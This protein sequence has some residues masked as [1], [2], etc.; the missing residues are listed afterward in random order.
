MTAEIMTG[1]LYL[2]IVVVFIALIREWRLRRW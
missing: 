2:V 1:V